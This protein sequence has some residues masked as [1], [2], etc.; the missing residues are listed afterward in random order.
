MLGHQIKKYCVFKGND[1]SRMLFC[2]L[3]RSSVY[4]SWI[5]DETEPNGSKCTSIQPWVE[6]LDKLKRFTLGWG[7]KL[8]YQKNYMQQSA[9][10]FSK[11]TLPYMKQG[12]LCHA[13]HTDTKNTNT[14]P[15]LHLWS[16][17]Q[18]TVQNTAH[19]F[20][21]CTLC[22]RIKTLAVIGKTRTIQNAK[23]I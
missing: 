9:K 1:K 8:V 23:H 15:A 2:S 17:L 5:L 13:F 6:M 19:S 21:P 10:R 11:Y 4:S 20:L 16:I 12:R 22:S 14:F 18:H 3:R 7:R